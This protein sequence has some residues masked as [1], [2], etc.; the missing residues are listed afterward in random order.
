MHH[1]VQK[2]PEPAPAPLAFESVYREHFAMV[3]RALRRFGVPECDLPDAA[4]DLF[5]VVHRKLAEFDGR[6]RVSTWLY[7][8]C[9]RVASDRRRR[10]QNRHEAFVEEP[11]EARA[12]GAVHEP[13]ELA[14]RRALLQGALDAMPLEQRSVFVLFELE[15]M[16]GEEIATVVDAPLAT[17]HSR[18]RLSRETFRRVVGRARAREEFELARMG[19]KP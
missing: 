18:L 2:L 7:A 8:I 16:T 10:A 12:S 9:V 19:V 3:W 17:V 14:E 11:D 5:V 1:A 6:C 15:G 13:W 4:Q